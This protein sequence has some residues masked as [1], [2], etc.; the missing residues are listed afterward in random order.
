[1]SAIIEM[2]AEDRK[3]AEIA[4]ILGFNPNSPASWPIQ[5]IKRLLSLR[6]TKGEIAFGEA[7]EA[8]AARL[9]WKMESLDPSPGGA[10]DW[11]ALDESDKEFFRQCIKA[12]AQE[13]LLLGSLYPVT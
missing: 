11:E 12:L 7:V 4:A 2:M 3:I 5:L 1:M 13:P 10:T 8:L 6:E 9:H